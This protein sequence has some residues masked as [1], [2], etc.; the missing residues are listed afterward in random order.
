MSIIKDEHEL[1][2][3]PNQ[4][5]AVIQCGLTICHPGHACLPR[6][7]NHYSAHFILEGKGT[8]VVNGKSYE[9]KAGQGFLITP[10]I[11]NTYIADIQEPWRYIY[12][13]FRGLDAESLVHSCGLNKDH[14]I[15]SFP[16]A[17]D[18]IENLYAM[19]ESSK[20]YDSKGYDVIGYFL[21]VM[22]QLIKANKNT[23]KSNSFPEHLCP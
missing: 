22:S 12:A 15:F 4:S 19:Y 7:Y 5:L 10:G 20:S 9:L 13:T 14:V 6:I 16:T 8:Y 18:I 3:L 21:L 1:K 2:K 17:P 23:D 11:S